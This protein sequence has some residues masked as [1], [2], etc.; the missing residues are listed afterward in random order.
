[1]KRIFTLLFAIQITFILF[2]ND[3]SCQDLNKTRTE[4]NKLQIF[5]SKASAGDF[6]VAESGKLLTVISIRSISPKSVVLEEIS[7][8]IKNIKPRPSSW[9]DWVKNKSPGHSSWSLIEIDL[10]TGEILKCYSFS[11]SSHIQITSK[12]SLFAT[13]LQLPLKAVPSDKRRRIGPPPSSGE[14]DF[15]KLWQ[16]PLVFEGTPVKNSSFHVF[17]TNWP[18]DGTELEGKEI[19]LYFDQDM[20]IPLPFW[21]QAETAH[22]TFHLRTI[23]SGKNLSSPMRY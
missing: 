5:L 14:S 21:I 20:R 4:E 13:L 18:K 16:P 12:E 1:M 17:E 7:A 9:K 19:T 22:A 10:G 2:A 3:L 23:D 6:I 11:R 15:R 8:P